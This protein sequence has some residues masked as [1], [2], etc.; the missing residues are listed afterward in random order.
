MLGIVTLVSATIGLFGGARLAEVLG[1]RHDDANM[2][3]LFLAQFLSIPLLA[4]GPLMP[5]PWLALACGA[6]GSGIGAMGGAGYNAAINL[7]TPNEMRG[8]I[9]VMYFILMNAIAGSLGPTLV[10]L[11]TDN[12][13]RSEADLRYVISGCRLVLGPLTAFFLWKAMAPYARVFRQ[14][15][16]E[17]AI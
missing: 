6:I 2:R 7:A 5:S 13:A 12:V 4:A 11:L 9:N 1:R 10:A 15:I 16:E 14:R 3:V 17:N 8:Q